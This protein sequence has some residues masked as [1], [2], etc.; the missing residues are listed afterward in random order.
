MPLTLSS[1]ITI[2]VIIGGAIGL[3]YFAYSVFLKDCILL[4]KEKRRRTV[5]EAGF[6]ATP[7]RPSVTN[8][9]TGVV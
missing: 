6:G 2:F 5:T 4:F 7:V 9:V 3:L 8:G 1:V